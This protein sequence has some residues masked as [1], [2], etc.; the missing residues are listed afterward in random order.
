MECRAGYGK[1]S[2]L[3]TNTSLLF[4][5]PTYDCAPDDKKQSDQHQSDA[6]WCDDQSETSAQ[7]R[8]QNSPSQRIDATLGKIVFGWLCLRRDRRHFFVHKSFCE[9]LNSPRLSGSAVRIT[10]P[11]SATNFSTACSVVAEKSELACSCRG[12]LYTYSRF[13]IIDLRLLNTAKHRPAEYA[14]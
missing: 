11:I 1:A 2:S 10:L 7:K 5:R 3:A 9:F 12:P 6:D 4:F 14:P 8:Q 13:D